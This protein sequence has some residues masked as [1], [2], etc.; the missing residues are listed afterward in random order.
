MNDQQAGHGPA[1]YADR[2]RRPGLA[3][4]RPAA[5]GARPAR[6][7]PPAAAVLLDV[8]CVLAFVA[9]GRASHH[10]GDSPA[11]LISTAWPFLA[12]LAAGLVATRAWRRPAAIVPAGLGAWL[13]T[14][15]VGMLL[16]VVAGQG[17]ALAFI[18][19]ALAFLGL[20]LLGW[21]AVAAV[22]L[23]S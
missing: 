7:V 23:R 20:F 10:D 3:A 14:V 12:G 13:G 8:C 5:S 4:S 11:G 19:V 17:T 9:I 2:M 15:V 18:G 1:A 16:R 6:R 21:R 22:L